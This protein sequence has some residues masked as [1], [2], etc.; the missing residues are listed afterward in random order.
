M[1]LQGGNGLYAT[2]PGKVHKGGCCCSL[3][4]ICTILGGGICKGWAVM[5][6]VA[7]Y[8]VNASLASNHPSCSMCCCVMSFHGNP[9]AGPLERLFTGLLRT[10]CL[11]LGLSLPAVML[12]T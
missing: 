10:L 9:L 6:F 4:L 11:G 3:A 7:F 12:T 8:G 2:D 5:A 1:Q